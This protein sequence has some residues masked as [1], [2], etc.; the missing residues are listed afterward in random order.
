MKPVKQTQFRPEP[1]HDDTGNCFAACVATIFELPLKDVPNFVR[2]PDWVERL[3]AWCEDRGYYPV[4]PYT[5]LPPKGYA[6]VTAKSP[7]GPFGHSVVYFNGKLAHDPHPDGGGVILEPWKTA[8][9]TEHPWRAMFFAK[10][11]PAATGAP[12]GRTEGR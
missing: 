5:W 1:G 12:D 8:D 3:E 6:I 2:Y 10:M 4:E 11:D 9:G 7:R